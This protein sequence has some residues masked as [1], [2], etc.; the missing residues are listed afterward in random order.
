[1]GA[2]FGRGVGHGARVI[3]SG[4]AVSGTRAKQ[5]EHIGSPMTKLVKKIVLRGIIVI[6]NVVF[7]CVSI[8]IILKQ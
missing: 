3:R 2:G 1:M 7:L 4:M 6:I 8:Q 5:S